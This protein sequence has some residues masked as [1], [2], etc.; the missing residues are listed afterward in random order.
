VK[1]SQRTREDAP[2]RRGEARESV[3]HTS[4]PRPPRAA[5]LADQQP[6]KWR[7]LGRGTRTRLGAAYVLLLVLSATVSTLAIRQILV[8]R[9]EERMDDALAKEY[10]EIDRH[11]AAGRNPVTGRAFSNLRALFDSYFAQHVL[12]NEEAVL[13]FVEGRPYR[14]NLEQFPLDRLPADVVS[15]WAAFSAVPPPAEDFSGEFSTRLGEGRFR[16]AHVT[17][18][19]RTGAFVVAMLPAGELQEIGELQRFGIAATLGVLLLASVAAWFII[20]RTLRP[21]RELTETARSIS[22]SDLASRVEVQGS[23][24]AAV[25][26]QSFNRMLDRIEAVFRIQRE[27]VQDASHELRDPLTI[28]RG[29]LEL[30]GDDPDERHATVALVLDELDRMGRV[31]DDLQLLADVAQPDFIRPEE[32]DLEPF[33]KELVTKASALAS[34]DWMLAQAASGTLVADRHRLTEAVMNLAHNAAQHTFPDESVAIGTEVHDGEARIWVADAGRGILLSD[35]K[36]IFD[37]F[38]RGRGS[39]RRYSGS[40]LGLAIVKA[41]AEAHGGRV[42]VESEF[43]AGST[44]TIV[45]P[46]EPAARGEPWP[47]S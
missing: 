40:G 9:L 27:F 3:V 44:F 30:L 14:S 16:T 32:I 8:V 15:R 47:G 4:D 43:G 28:C 1:A 22:E 13:T 11:V 23:D 33:T 29:H 10:A 6:R 45:L 37:R 21:V 38:T 18:D 34:R 24:E 19:D 7:V 31:V 12:D 41:V 46:L 26:A 36:R 2:D 17:L 5:E 42:E 39:N 20:G 35:Q 25:M